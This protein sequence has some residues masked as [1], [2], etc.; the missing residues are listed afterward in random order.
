MKSFIS[1]FA[2]L[3]GSLLALASMNSQAADG[4]ISFTGTVSD[5]TCSINGTASGSP[6]DLS[7]TLPTVSASTLASQ[8]SVAGTSS[9]TDLVFALTNCSGTATKAIASFENGPT[10]DQTTGYLKN[11]AAAGAATNVQVRLLNASLLPIN[12]TT[13]ENNSIAN[14]AATITGGNANLK[15]FAQYYATG[16]ATSGAVNTTVQYTMQYQ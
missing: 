16:K 8:G 10:V 1:A 2:V 13:G 4:T 6:A 5:T 12:I 9:P 3:T 15:Y 11:Q 14:N 7:V